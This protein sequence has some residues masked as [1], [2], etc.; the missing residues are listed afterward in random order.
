MIFFFFFRSAPTGPE[1]ETRSVAS[2]QETCVPYSCVVRPGFLGGEKRLKKE[3]H[4]QNQNITKTKISPKL[5]YHREEEL[6]L[7]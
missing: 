2:S 4:H 3:K 6:P 5:K 1:K 7:I